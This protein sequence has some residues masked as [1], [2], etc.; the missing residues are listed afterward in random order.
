MN[1]PKTKEVIETIKKSMEERVCV[2]CGLDEKDTKDIKCNLYGV[3]CT[4]SG[5]HLLKYPSKIKAQPSV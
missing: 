3:L 2:R 4:P 1:T 5:R